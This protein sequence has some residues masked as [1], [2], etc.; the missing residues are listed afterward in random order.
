MKRSGKEMEMSTPK[1]MHN[2]AF[3][4]HSGGQVQVYSNAEHIYLQMRREVLTEQDILSPSFKVAVEL[5]PAE[6]LSLAVELLTLA[7][8]RL[9][10]A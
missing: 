7:S 1:G 5:T 6:A 2:R 4:L 9:T 3:S 10:N 8:P